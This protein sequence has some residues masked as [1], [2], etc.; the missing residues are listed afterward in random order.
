MQILF[1]ESFEKDLKRIRDRKIKNRVKEIIDEVRKAGNQQQISNLKKLKD[2]KT[3]YR[4][5]VGN[6][7]VG[8]EIIQDKV[9]FTRFLNRKDIYKYFP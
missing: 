3:Y 9:I 4:I 7:R 8:I 1:E 2:Y 6:Y 5:R